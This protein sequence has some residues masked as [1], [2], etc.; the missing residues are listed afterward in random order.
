MWTGAYWE[1]SLCLNKGVYRDDLSWNVRLS[2]PQRR[3]HI[4][5]NIVCSFPSDLQSKAQCYN[6]LSFQSR[7]QF[8]QSLVASAWPC[9][10]SVIKRWPL[11]AQQGLFPLN[12][13]W[14]SEKHWERQRECVCVWERERES[15][16]DRSQIKTLSC[17]SAFP[18]IK[19]CLCELI[20]RA[21]WFL[22]VNG[23]SWWGWKAAQGEITYSRA[24]FIQELVVMLASTN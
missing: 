10:P 1:M 6:S 8:V 2:A 13:S 21:W 22:M 16:K 3:N 18:P 12:K 20:S 4:H 5:Y 9:T 17:F 7:A 11:D 15:E 24:V 14:K 23:V 19:P